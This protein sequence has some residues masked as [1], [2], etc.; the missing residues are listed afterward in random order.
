MEKSSSSRR[1]TPTRRTSSGSPRLVA[2]LRERDEVAGVVRTPAP[3]RRRDPVRALL[4]RLPL[5]ARVA[6]AASRRSR[7]RLSFHAT[8]FSNVNSAVPRAVLRA[9]S[10]GRRRDHERGPGVVAASPARGPRDRVRATR[11]GAALA[12]LHGRERVQALLRLR[13]VG[14]SCVRERG[15]VVSCRPARGRPSL[16]ARRGVVALAHGTSALASV[17]S[18]LRVGEVRGPA[19]GAP[20][21]ADSVVP[22]AASFAASRDTGGTNGPRTTSRENVLSRES[23]SSTTISSHRRSEGRNGGCATWRST[24]PPRVT[25]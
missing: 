4:P 3:A 20:P 8:L 13:R 16:R 2:P 14:R 24:S 12:R 6:H 22:Q 18:R 23:A 15:A 5:R 9:L 1:R 21:P 17:R 10:A 7:S 19:A 11:R 25:T